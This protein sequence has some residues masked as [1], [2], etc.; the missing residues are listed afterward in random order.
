MRVWLFNL[1]F[2]AFTF[3][4]AGLLWVGCFVLPQTAVR[5]FIAWWSRRVVGAV[6]L[7]LRGDPQ[8]LGLERLPPGGPRIIAAKHQ[9]ELDAIM[10]FGLFPHCGAVVMKEL[11]NYP[12]I[13]RIIAK[14]ELIAVSVKE[15]PQGRSQAVVQGAAAVLAQGRP[16]LIYPEATLMSLGARERYRSGVWRI[17]AA[18]GQPVTPVAQSL[19]AI[20][21]RREW[22]KRVGR[23]GA[24]AFLDPIQPGLDQAEFMAQLEARIEDATMSLIRAH[25]DGADLAAAEDRFARRAANED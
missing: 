6:R 12:F 15:G 1:W 24:I 18:S 19:G 5:A 8:V 14:L 17:Y 22:R 2:Y 13:G 10:L 11:E 16:V 3:V 25:A 23:T 4:C 20:W 7:I 9:S 21:P